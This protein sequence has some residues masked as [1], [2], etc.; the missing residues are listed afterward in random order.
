VKGKVK[1]SSGEMSRRI[2]IS[3]RLPA[4]KIP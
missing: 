3:L 2:A 4:P 1:E